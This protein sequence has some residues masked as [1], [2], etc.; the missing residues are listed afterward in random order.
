M[1]V[2]LCFLTW[3]PQGLQQGFSMGGD[4]E[5]IELSVDGV[6]VCVDVSECIGGSL[7]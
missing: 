7:C 5:D 4:T 2:E 1:A 6:S 3:W